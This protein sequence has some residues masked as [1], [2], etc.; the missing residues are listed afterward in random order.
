MPATLAENEGSGMK[1]ARRLPE[2]SYHD[3]AERRDCQTC[4]PT[5]EPKMPMTEDKLD[6]DPWHGG[7]L[8][9]KRPK[10]SP[11]VAVER[12]RDAASS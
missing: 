1:L 4:R 2:R 3:T 5:S 7:S 6:V 12:R 9:Q 11:N 10:T 8:I